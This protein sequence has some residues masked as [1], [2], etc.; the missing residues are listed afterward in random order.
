M[1]TVLKSLSAARYLRLN[2]RKL[3]KLSSNL[4]KQFESEKRIQK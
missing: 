4:K 2:L 3:Y 1:Y